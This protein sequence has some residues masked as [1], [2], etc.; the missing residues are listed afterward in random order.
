MR[1]I[2]AHKLLAIRAILTGF[3]VL[4]PLTAAKHR[5]AYLPWADGPL[6]FWSL[7]CLSFA[8][9]GW[10]VART[11]RGH[12]APMVMAFTVY[13]LAYKVLMFTLV[14]QHFQSASDPLQ[15]PLDFALTL[16]SVLCATAGGLPGWD[17]DESKSRAQRG[18][19]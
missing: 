16:L 19:D 5:L 13:A 2:L 1:E 11:H 14:F 10:V 6:Q 18:T 15:L 12:H 17:L 8:V 7:T 9:S 4:L 3:I